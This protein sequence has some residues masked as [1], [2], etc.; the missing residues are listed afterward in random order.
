MKTK[1]IQKRFPATID[2]NKKTFLNDKKVD[3]ELYAYLQSVSC[4]LNNQTV[5]IKKEL[6]RKKDICNKI[7]VKSVKTLNA[8]MD[9][10]IENGYI[11]D[12]QENGVY[13]LP[14]IEDFYA[15]IPLETI[16]FLSDTL[17]ENVIK[18]Y[19]YLGQRY[20]FKTNYEFTL[21]ELAAN[22]GIKLNHVSRNYVMMNNILT[23]LQILGL[24]DFEVINVSN[25]ETKKRLTFFSFYV[26]DTTR[27]SKNI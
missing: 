17:Q 27:K 15:L 6:P 23:C 8:H 10:L 7:G 20:K 25:V 18:V 11:T 9:Y 3:G 14:N 5:I 19:I 16:Q 13:V 1:G 22:I 4:V 26:N 12:D 2:L 24:I 21:E